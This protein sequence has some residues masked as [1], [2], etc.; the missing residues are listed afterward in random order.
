LI[1]FNLNEI[2]ITLIKRMWFSDWEIH[3]IY[4]FLQWAPASVHINCWLFRW[5]E[6]EFFKFLC[7]FTLFLFIWIIMLC[8]IHRCWF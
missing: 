8:V 7:F 6:N 5:T 3:I 2:K 4:L 1:K